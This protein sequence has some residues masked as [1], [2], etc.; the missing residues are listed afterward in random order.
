MSP[1]P[2]VIP[3]K[4]ES[5]FFWTDV[6]PGLRGGDDNSPSPDR[7]RRR[8]LY[9]SGCRGGRRLGPGHFYGAQRLV[10]R[11]HVESLV[12]RAGEQ[13]A[14]MIRS[15]EMILAVKSMKRPLN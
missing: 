9:N 15:R 14:S 10:A 11:L 2:S 3:R 6:D 5:S 1:P 13:A 4:R 8:E 12:F 7:Y